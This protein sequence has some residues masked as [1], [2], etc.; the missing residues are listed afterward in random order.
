LSYRSADER[1]SICAGSLGCI[2]RVDSDFQH[3]KSWRT[4]W[5]TPAKKP[6]APAHALSRVETDQ[7]KHRWDIENKF[8]RA[9]D[10]RQVTAAQRDQA[11]A[12]WS[13]LMEVKDIAEPMR[14]IATFG[15]P[16]PL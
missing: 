3:W 7:I 13:N 5:T 6:L 4:I 2:T 11:H 1:I 15:K 9:F 16:L 8:K 12:A 10:Y 14:A